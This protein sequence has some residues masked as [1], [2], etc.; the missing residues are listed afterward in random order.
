MNDRRVFI[1]GLW[2]SSRGTKGSFFRER[3][4]DMIIEDFRGN[5]EQRMDKLNNLLANETSLIMVGSSYGGLMAAIYAFN[6][7]G[8]VKKLVLMAPALIS[9]GFEPYLPKTTDIPVTIYHGEN[10]DVV[11]L[12][13][14]H[15]IAQR[16]FQNLTFKM[17]DDDHVLSNTFTSIDWESLL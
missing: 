9:E 6:N 4:P 15:N 13:P 2:G 11:P 10:D 8:K 1:H 5:L 17:V 16:V 7:Q 3:Y 12:T 14:V